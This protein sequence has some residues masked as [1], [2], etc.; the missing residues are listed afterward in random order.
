MCHIYLGFDVMD[1]VARYSWNFLDHMIILDRTFVCCTLIHFTRYWHSVNVFHQLKCHHLIFWATIW[2]DNIRYTLVFCY[3]GCNSCTFPSK[4]TAVDQILFLPNLTGFVPYQLADRWTATPDMRGSAPPVILL[5]HQK[6]NMRL[7]E[8][9]TSTANRSAAHLEES[10]CR[11]SW[12]HY[13]RQQRNRS[14]K[15]DSK[16]L[17]DLKKSS[18]PGRNK[19]NPF[20]FHIVAFSVTVCFR[21]LLIYCIKSWRK[22]FKGQGFLW[23]PHLSLSKTWTGIG[24]TLLLPRPFAVVPLEFSVTCLNELRFSTWIHQQSHCEK[25][26]QQ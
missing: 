16:W 19:Y 17:K 18:C 23:S 24:L 6:G 13:R 10:V 20:I 5:L 12:Q 14:K 3:Q 15:L 22:N 25:L 11:P 9:T 26:Q 1:N 8:E 2:H 4:R 7:G 21:K